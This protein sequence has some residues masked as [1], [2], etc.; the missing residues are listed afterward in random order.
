MSYL[1]T[2]EASVEGDQAA[3]VMVMSL[4]GLVAAQGPGLAGSV[5]GEG[6]VVSTRTWCTL[7]V[8]SPDGLIRL[9]ITYAQ[10]L[11]GQLLPLSGQLTATMTR[12]MVTGWSHAWFAVLMQSPPPPLPGR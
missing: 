5:G 11:P 1:A 10:I 6:G 7:K 9:A 4:N 2:P 12:S 3:K 8:G